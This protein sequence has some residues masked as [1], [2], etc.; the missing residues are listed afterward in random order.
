MKQYKAE[1]MSIV[2]CA[3]MLRSNAESESR[4]VI[5]QMNRHMLADFTIYFKLSSQGKLL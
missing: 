5:T 4:P 2:V 3:H 1:I